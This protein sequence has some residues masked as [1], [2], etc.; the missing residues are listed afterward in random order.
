MQGFSNKRIA[1]GK[2]FLTSVQSHGIINA[3]LTESSGLVAILHS[4]TKNSEGA[5]IQCKL[6]RDLEILVLPELKA[7]KP[8]HET[9]AL[10]VTKIT[11]LFILRN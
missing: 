3:S 8:H 2:G 7:E 1:L 5:N 6:T 10:T 9:S 11:L 4:N